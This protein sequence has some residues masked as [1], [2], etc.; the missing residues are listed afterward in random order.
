MPSEQRST[1]KLKACSTYY[2][3]KKKTSDDFNSPERARHLARE[4]QRADPPLD[5]VTTAGTYLGQSVGRDLQKKQRSQ[6]R[7][8]VGTKLMT[9][10]TG[11]EVRA[12]RSMKP[13]T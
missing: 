7:Y 2:F 4:K 10:P 3:E 11:T 6:T 12:H 9:S 1:T 8:I 5:H 13:A